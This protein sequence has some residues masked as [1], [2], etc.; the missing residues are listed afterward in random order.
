VLYTTF[1]SGFVLGNKVIHVDVVDV[2]KQYL[3]AQLLQLKEKQTSIPT[4]SNV[5]KVN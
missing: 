1:L 4:E 3:Q 5:P 2:G